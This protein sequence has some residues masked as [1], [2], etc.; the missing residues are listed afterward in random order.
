[1]KGCIVFHIPRPQAQRLNRGSSVRERGIRTKSQS[2]AFFCGIRRFAPPVAAAIGILLFPAPSSFSQNPYFQF[3][4]IGTREGLSMAN[5]MAIAEDATGFMWFGTEDGL[6]RFDG[7]QFTVYRAATDDTTTINNSYVSTL[8]LDSRK[9]LWVGTRDGL[10]RYVPERD[11]FVRYPTRSDSPRNPNN[12]DIKCIFEDSRGFLWI[13]GDTGADRLSP[14]DG[15]FRHFKNDPDKPTSLSYNTAYAVTETRD[16][17]I[18]IGTERGLNRMNPTTGRCERILSRGPRTNSPSSDYIRTLLPDGGG[19]LWIGTYGGGLDHFDFSANRYVHFPFGPAGGRSISNDQV[20][21]IAA[22]WDGN[23]WVGTTEGLNFIRIDRKNLENSTVVRY[24]EDPDTPGSL[25]AGHIQQIRADSDRVWL[26]TRFGGVNRID[27]YGGKFRK[28]TRTSIRGRG[29]SYPNVSCFA[30]DDQGRVY[31]GSDGGGVSIMDPR[32]SRFDYLSQN[33]GGRSA[34]ASNKVLALL[35]QPPNV[36]WIGTWNGGLDRYRIDTRTTTHYRMRPSDRGS[37]SGDNVF[38]LLL[39]RD[40]RVWAGTWSGGLNRYDPAGDRFIRYPINVS[41]GTGTSGQTVMQMRQASDGAIWLA[42]EGNG[43]NRLDPATGRFTYYRSRPADTA[44]LSGDYVYGIH[45]DG[46]KRIWLATTNGLC[47]LAGKNGRFTRFH[48]KDGLPSETLYGILE[49]GRGDLW[50]SSIKGLSRIAVG[51]A[52]DRPTIRCTNYTVR[53]GLQGEQFGQWAY[54]ED[55]AG[56]MYFGGVNG[57]NRFNPLDI[58][59]NPVPPRVLINDFQLSFK[60]CSFREPG[61]PL[62]KPAYLSDAITVS[63]RESMLTFGFVAIGYTRAEDNRYAYK[64]ENFDRKWLDVGTDRRATYTNLNPGRYTFRVRAANNDGVWNENGAAIRLTITPPFWRR[65]WFI[66]LMVLS[67]VAGAGLLFRWRVRSLEAARERLEAEIAQRTEEIQSKTREI[68]ASYRRLSETGQTLA[69]LA[70]QVNRAT[71]RINDTMNRVSGGAESQNENAELTRKL[72]SRLLSSIA[73]VTSQTRIS[74]RSAAETANAVRTG[75]ASM[76]TALDAMQAIEKDVSQTWELM[77]KL[78]THSERIDDIV[79]LVD[80]IASRVNV[81][82]LNALIEAFRAGEHG[83]GFM[84]VAQEIRDLSRRTADSIQEI[85]GAVTGIQEDVKTIEGFTREGI[86]RMKDS[87]RVTGEGRTVLDR[88]CQSVEEEKRRI[89]SIAERLGE[90]QTASY[91]V[92]KAIENVESVSRQNLDG[93]A[94]VKERTE[95]VGLR[96]QELASLAQTLA[97]R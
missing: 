8:F 15:T 20:N 70:L 27:R 72:V 55:R 44:S 54:F 28:F 37:L 93:V 66:A 46:K 85:T 88:I 33:S 77:R 68:E 64:L 12:R 45:E 6:N 61:S 18:W 53:D 80:D 24:L 17:R 21:S 25:S 36:L 81:L 38:S 34:I 3:E 48:E 50:V 5:V 86:E 7:Y 90:M 58:R 11:A 19:G 31:I 63:Y 94:Q 78:R 57:F 51:G 97:D 69:S 16:G 96:I 1:M 14:T 39:D 89:A 35:F 47:C 49:D 43:L 75:T 30:E 26:A 71:A 9:Q 74:T 22:H 52:A 60:S 82:A 32:T 13:V 10:C 65:L 76:S 91:E 59:I 84:V 67:A 2:R 40:R 73:A 79:R 41:D 23:L 92:Q 4:P 42:T 56:T 87:A 95:E 29:I 62:K 83:R